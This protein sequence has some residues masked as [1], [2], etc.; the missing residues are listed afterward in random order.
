MEK[1]NTR[2]H[3]LA[4]I[5]IILW[6]TTFISTKILLKDFA[7]IEI[8][9]YRFILG[10]SVLF[11][12]YP[13]R[14]VRKSLMQELTF[15]L[16]GLCGVTLY[17]LLENIALTYTM[18][19]N[20]GVIVSISP[21]LTALLTQLFM[22]KEEGLK[23][24][25]II[26]F[27]I[28]VVGI[29]LI[30]FNASQLKLNPL[31]DILAMSAALAWAFYSVLIRKISSYGYHTIQ[32]TRRIFIYGILF[33][34]PSLL[35]FDIKWNVHNIIKPLNLFNLIFL[36]I[37][38]SAI[39]FVSWNFAVKLLGAVRTSIYIYLVP[40]VT[41]ITS[42]L[43]LREKI[44]FVAVLGTIFILIGLFVSESRISKRGFGQSLYRIKDT[45]ITKE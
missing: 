41:V 33:M 3:I 21:F 40:V 9:F 7:P 2:G 5:T 24:S 6:G 23:M 4:L 18:A 32:T 29:C 28:A 45:N 26:G 8:L 12:L 44:T 1:K 22:K 31:G 34:L 39:C 10:V 11:L 19:S 25:F 36:G 42:L 38:A 15:A 43:V 17:F 27:I 30:S 35:L 14:L 20:V 13:K 37:G 16:A